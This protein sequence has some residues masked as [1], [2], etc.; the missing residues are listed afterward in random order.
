MMSTTWISMFYGALAFVSFFFYLVVL[1]FALL[2]L[3]QHPKPARLVGLAMV[4]L[5]LTSILHPVANLLL[6]RMFSTEQFMMA[7]MV[8]SLLSHVMHYAAV[9]LLVVA[10]FTSRS[11]R[12]FESVGPSNVT[13]DNPYGP[14]GAHR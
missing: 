4:I 8:V 11:E 1:V 2:K 9:A 13:P 10:A 3:A 6:S 5:M 7:N 14:P 12:Q